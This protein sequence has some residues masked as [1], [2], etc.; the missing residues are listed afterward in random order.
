MGVS[1]VVVVLAVKKANNQY[2]ELRFGVVIV[3]PKIRPKKQLLA[4]DQSNTEPFWL[5]QL[6]WVFLGIQWYKF[7]MIRFKEKKSVGLYSIKPRVVQ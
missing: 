2:L 3:N 7:M 6:A 1:K 4:N 5:K